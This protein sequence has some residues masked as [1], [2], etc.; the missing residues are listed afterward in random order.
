MAIKCDE[1]CGE[2]KNTECLSYQI[3]KRIEKTIHDEN[4]RMRGSNNE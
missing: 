4:H 3:N 2:C 1:H